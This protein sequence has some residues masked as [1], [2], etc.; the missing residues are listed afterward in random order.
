MKRLNYLWC[1]VLMAVMAV[2]CSE[3]FDTPPM[4]VPTALNKPN[5]TLAEFK[6]KYWDNARN[7][8][9]TVKEDIVIHGYVSG[10][11]VSGN[12]YK[13]M[14]I[15]DETAGGIPAARAGRAGR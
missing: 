1:L 14:Y 9:D 3:D 15:Q 7:F 2:S 11:D 13:V 4:V 5:M 10:N 6:A 12:L 8:C